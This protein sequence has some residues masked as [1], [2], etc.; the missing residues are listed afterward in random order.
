[1][2]FIITELASV[3]YQQTINWVSSQ[4]S[5]D[6]LLRDVDFLKYAK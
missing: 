4:V 5:E 1:M 2:S 3:D 6:N